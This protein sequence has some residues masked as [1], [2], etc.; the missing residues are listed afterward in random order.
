MNVHGYAAFNFNWTD[1]QGPGLYEKIEAVRDVLAGHGLRDLEMI[2]TETGWHS[3]TT[4]NAGFSDEEIQSRYVTELFTESRAAD[5]SM[6]TWWMLY[7]LRD[8]PFDN[9]LVTLTAEKKKSFTAFH[10]AIDALRMTQPAGVLSEAQTGNDLMAVYKF[11]YAHN[12]NTLYV[13]WMN[14]IDTNATDTL[15]VDGTVASVTNIY[16]ESVRSVVTDEDDGVR[17]GRV[18]VQVS[19]QPIY[20]E[21]SK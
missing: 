2:I 21:V 16:G 6:M 9:G 3:N 17:D 7:D 20:L 13:A 10:Y 18:T 4:P 1:K 5:I 15:V 14:P 19:G 12:D 11:S 8:Y